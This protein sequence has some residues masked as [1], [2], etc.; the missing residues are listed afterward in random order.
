MENLNFEP[1]LF[2]I[3]LLK[4]LLFKDKRFE[5]FCF[6]SSNFLPSFVRLAVNSLIGNFTGVA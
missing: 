2:K 3:S 6:Y 1:F 5:S 4:L